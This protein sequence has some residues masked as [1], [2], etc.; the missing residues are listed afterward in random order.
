MES[1]RKKISA[2]FKSKVALATLSE[3]HT[4]AERI[5]DSLYQQVGQYF[6][7][8]NHLRPHQSLN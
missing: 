4:V 8:Y 6:H 3:L 1:K 7:F 2:E 5:T